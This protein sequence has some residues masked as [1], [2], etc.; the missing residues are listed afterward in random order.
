[1]LRVDKEERVMMQGSLRGDGLKSEKLSIIVPA[2]NEE[3]KI[4]EN[5]VEIV[6]SIDELQINHEII[7]VNDG[8][9]DETLT[10]VS[11][12][13]SENIK[14]VG[15]TENQGKGNAIRYGFRF[16]TGDLV[17]FIDA[18]MDL[19]PKQI[20]TLV[21]YMNKSGADVVVGSKRHPLSKVDYPLD[22]RVLSRGYQ[23]LNRI[24]FGLSIRDT[25]VGLKLF[26]YNVLGDVMPKMVVK[27]YAYDIELMANAH[28]KGYSITE[29]PIELNHSF[30]SKVDWNEIYHMF[31]DTCGVFY[32]L[33]VAK[34]YD[35]TIT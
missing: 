21:E 2:Y 13:K 34:Y 16:A 31:V 11:K 28:H 30:D 17:V 24:L 20:K 33:K 19:H 32:R 22:R 1:M 18:D 3:H 8:S 29:A 5:L 35:R 4:C 27:K 15:Y 23:T 7:V 26:K 14:I 9:T 6:K 10:E 12:L 25:Q